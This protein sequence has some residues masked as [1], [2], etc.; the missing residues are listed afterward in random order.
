M[1]YNIVAY[2]VF[3]RRVKKR[4]QSSKTGEFDHGLSSSGTCH[5]SKCA[6][7]P[8]YQTADNQQCRTYFS[9]FGSKSEKFESELEVLLSKNFP[10]IN[11]NVV[12]TNS[13][14]K[15]CMFQYKDVTPKS[16]RSN[17]IYKYRC[18]CCSSEYEL[19]QLL[20]LTSHFRFV[21]H[22]RDLE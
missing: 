21:I 7:S 8:V 13:L 10:Q 6:S 12:L 1:K 2:Q 14:E 18:E 5:Q 19:Y 3:E 17:V 16:I 4:I 22:P 20:V 11:L 15:V 9:Q